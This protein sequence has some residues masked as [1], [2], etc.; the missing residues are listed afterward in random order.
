MKITRF[1][2][3]AAILLFLV[4]CSSIRV[5]SDYD[6][7]VDFNQYKTFAFF[8]EGIDQVKLNDLDKKRILNAIDQELTAKGFVKTDQNPDFLINIFTKA[9]EQVNIT[10]N[11]FFYSPWG[12]G[13]GWHP[14]WGPSRTMVTTS[15]EGMLYI[16][17]L[18]TQKKSLVWQGVGT[19][20]LSNSSK[21]EQK[22]KKIQEFVQ[23]ILA[24]FP[25][26]K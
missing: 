1:F 17:I 23:K 16:D 2:S 7:D 24:K 6:K 12:Y 26:E 21:T 8:K 18:D 14:Y 11:N 5:T 20:Y 22:E 9:Q 19:G 4:S 25:V 13:W 10:N 15:T 3:T